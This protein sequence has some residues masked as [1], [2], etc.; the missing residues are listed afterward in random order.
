MKKKA[1]FIPLLAAMAFASCSSDEIIENTGGNQSSEF[2]GDVAYMTVNIKDVNAGTKS[3][4]DGGYKNGTEHDV[5]DA[6]FFFFDKDGVFTSEASVWN[7]G[8]SISPDQNIEFIGANVIVLKNLTETG[9]PSYL[10]TVLN[11]P[12][13]KPEST[14]EATAKSLQMQC[15]NDISDT[16]KGYFVMSTSSYLGGSN[17]DDFI[18]EDYSPRYYTTKVNPEDFKKE[19]ATTSTASVEI[20]VERLAAKVEL[21]LGTAFQETAIDDMYKIK[22]SV[23]GNPNN[24]GDVNEGTTELYVKFLGWGLNATAKHTYLSKQLKQT[25]STVS[26]FQGWNITEDH[27]SFWAESN[28]YGKTSLQDSLN[29]ITYSN[30][31]DGIKTTHIE[32]CNENT[33]SPQNFLNNLSAN[34]TSVLVKAQICDAKGNGLDLVR[35]NGLMFKK[36]DFLQYVLNK[37]D[38][39]AGKLNIWRKVSTT[40]GDDDKEESQYKQIGADDVKLAYAEGTN[41]GKVLVKGNLDATEQ[42]Y[43]KEIQ[44]NKAVYTEYAKIAAEGEIPA[45]NAAID[46]LNN[47]LGNVTTEGEAFTG[48]AMYYNIPI[49]HQAASEGANNTIEGYYGVVRNHWY[50]LT[51]N[52]LSNLGH[53]VFIPEDGS[54]EKPII[55]EDPKDSYYLG[56]QINILS[57]KLINQNVN[58]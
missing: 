43:K 53:G 30:L 52:N 33:N 28:V 35:Y 11:A 13:F 45:T 25:W 44:D 32:Y 39:G 48:G 9:L 34:A 1:F 21:G 4:T 15:R 54:E 57:W 23:G 24:E 22:A 36:N 20:F 31:T 7:G 16:K 38:L 58:L 6:R 46:A 18:G 12:D 27:R 3:T 10:L 8:N 49:E 14:L 47:Y 2:V 26:P 29:Y 42:F 40:T 5:N 55:P 41:A 19:P 17:H 51:I 56:A 37:I 50:K